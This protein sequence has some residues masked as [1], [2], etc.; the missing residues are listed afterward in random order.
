MHRSPEHLLRGNKKTQPIL[1]V[2]WTDTAGN[3]TPKN[4]QTNKKAALW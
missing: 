2:G 4:A 3:D 1:G